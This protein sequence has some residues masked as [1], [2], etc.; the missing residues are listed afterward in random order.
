LVANLG[1]LIGIALLIFELR[2]AQHLAETDSAVRRLENIQAAQVQLALSDTFPEIRVKA[3]VEGVE[4]L[5]PAELSRVRAWELAVINRLQSYFVQYER[6]YLDESTAQGFIE[7]AAGKLDY[8][9]ELGVLG[10]AFEGQFASA[11]L[12]AAERN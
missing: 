1:V 2:Q 8:W 6:G 11:V 3:Q 12:E 10:D 9:E 5:T 4:S 7:F